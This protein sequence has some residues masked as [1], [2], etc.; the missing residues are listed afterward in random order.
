M[1]DTK[2]SNLTALLGANVQTST[3]VIPIVQ[4]S[5][6][7]TKKILV[8]ELF[9]ASFTQ[10][11]TATLTGC[12][13]SPTV[14]AVYSVTNNVVTLFVPAVTGTS[15]TTACTITGLPAAIIPATTHTMVPC[16]TEDNGGTIISACDV[17]SVLT[18]R[19]GTGLSLVFT[20]S[21]T[22]GLPFAIT[23]TYSLN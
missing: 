20:G 12:T 1:A 16:V 23:I 3:D 13:T 14:S 9:N 4:T 8:S 22:K 21:G 5:T 2:I 18:L 17:S 7:T 6:T 10:T 11:F 19:N 15:N